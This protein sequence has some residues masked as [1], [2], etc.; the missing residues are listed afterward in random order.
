MEEEKELCV[1][2]FKEITGRDLLTN[3][4]KGEEYIKLI[5]Y[6]RNE[7]VSL[8]TVSVRKSSV[9]HQIFSSVRHP[10]QRKH[11][12]VPNVTRASG[13]VRSSSH[14]ASEKDPTFVSNVGKASD[15][16]LTLEITREPTLARGP[17]NA[18]TVEKALVISQ[19]SPSTSKPTQVR[20]PQPAVGSASDRVF[21]P[22][23][24][25]ESTQEKNPLCVLSVG[26]ASKRHT[27]S[28]TVNFT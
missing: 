10:R 25:S 16:T 11:I 9:R 13:G 17:S 27:S 26:S 1:A 7:T 14:A 3:I 8:D 2:I 18:C 24:T 23:D 12:N 20:S 21:T 28:G 5:Q 22:T 19:C 15:E 6:L 4:S